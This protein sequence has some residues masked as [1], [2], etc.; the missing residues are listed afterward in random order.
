MITDREGGWAPSAGGSRCSR[1]D[2]LSLAGACDAGDN[3]RGSKLLHR[4]CES[5]TAR[6]KLKH[7]GES[8]THNV[9]TV[10]GAWG[11]SRD[12]EMMGIV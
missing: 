4:G 5:G 6:V 3:V 9:V 12:R 7:R 10:R 8:T 2:C 11:I 1:R